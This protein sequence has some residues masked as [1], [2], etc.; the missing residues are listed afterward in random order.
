V[1]RRR[2]STTG[3]DAREA[4]EGRGERELADMKIWSWRTSLTHPALSGTPLDRGDP[5]HVA[6]IP[7]YEEGWREATGCVGWARLNGYLVSA[8]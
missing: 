1:F 4:A 3:M 7:L 5:N 2:M 8:G 6:E